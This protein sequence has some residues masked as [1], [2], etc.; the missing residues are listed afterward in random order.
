MRLIKKFF[1]DLIFNLKSNMPVDINLTYKYMKYINNFNKFYWILWLF[2]LPFTFIIISCMFLI[3]FFYYIF[4][5]LNFILNF[6][7]FKIKIKKNKKVIRYKIIKTNFDNYI[8]IL[9]KSFFIESPKKIAFF[10]FYNFSKFLV[11]LEKSKKIVNFKLIVH[12]LYSIIIRVLIFFLTSIPYT[13]IKANTYFI[14][15]IIILK[16]YNYKN[17]Y[18][19]IKD[20]LVNSLCDLTYDIDNKIF[21]LRIIFY[22]KKIIFNTKEQFFQFYNK[23]IDLEK[24]KESV[25]LIKLFSRL[26]YIKHVILKEDKITNNCCE[27]LE[28][29]KLITTQPH[30]TLEFKLPFN[31]TLYINETSKNKMIVWNDKLQKFVTIYLN[32]SHLGNLNY[33]K[34]TYYTKSIIT[35]DINIIDD[36]NINFLIK[37]I[38]K[39]SLIKSNLALAFL[40]NSNENVLETKY[41]EK[42]SKFRF[43][44]KENQLEFFEKLDD[45]KKI[46]D[47]ISSVKISKNFLNINE[48]ILEKIPIINKVEFIHCCLNYQYKIE[49]FKNKDIIYF[50]FNKNFIK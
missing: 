48:E 6:V 18:I 30:L 1:N 38:Q 17:N 40:L 5:W 20:V 31:K 44:E 45:K 23:L 15:K 42:E 36:E 46:E 29:K 22:K 12:I 32:Y 4:F 9:L 25:E 28:K 19:F 24:F 2:L 43:I 16:N 21:F 8:I 49:Y 41:I 35:E 39:Q 50:L 34:K 37:K 13:I 11:N 10:I 26:S 3:G 7:K 47:L 27:L 14:A 33:Q